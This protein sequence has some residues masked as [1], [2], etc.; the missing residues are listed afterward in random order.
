M[1]PSGQE[2]KWDLSTAWWLS[3]LASCSGWLRLQY[4]SFLQVHGALTMGVVTMVNRHSAL[5]KT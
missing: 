1:A 3:L 2:E 5:T 4:T